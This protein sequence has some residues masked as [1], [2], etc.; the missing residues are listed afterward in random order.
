MSLSSAVVKGT[1]E[2]GS[3]KPYQV[4][5]RVGDN[6]YRSQHS[7]IFYAIFTR[8]GR[9]IRRSLKT[10][11]KRV[12]RA[13]LEEIRQA[14]MGV[15]CKS[16]S[17][18]AHANFEQ[19]A[20]VWLAS[21]S[22]N[23]RQR[24]LLRRQ[25]AIKA[26]VPHFSGSIRSITRMDLERWASARS[27]DVSPS[28]FNKEVETLRLTMEYCRELGAIIQNPAEYL[29]RRKIIKKQI[30]IPTHEQFVAL[31]AEL[32]KDYR[33]RGAGDLVELLA[34]SGA[35]LGEATSLRWCDVDWQ[36]DTL[37][38]GADGYTKNGECRTV[39]LFPA[40]KAFLQRLHEKTTPTGQDA[41]VPIQNAKVALK[42]AAKTLGFPRFTHHAF[43]HFFCTNAIENGVPF[44]VVAA[45]LG[46]K[47]GGV[48]VGKTY[49][50]LRNEHSMLMAQRMTFNAPAPETTGTPSNVVPLPI[51]VNQ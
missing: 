24:T 18:L 42:R 37:T 29:K 44:H 17:E 49:G 38:I 12:A 45:W 15:I 27:R 19:A 41:I 34:Y 5:T 21:V 51:A 3:E 28:T 32:R 13:R 8:N 25:A 9:Q 4:L 6:L 36:R 30:R 2:N 26:L 1:A 16:P 22:A 39:P 7:G 31:V 23:L 35:R 11:D 43:R 40:L 48:L 46:H 14:V 20:T 50:H 33:E 47:D 10:P